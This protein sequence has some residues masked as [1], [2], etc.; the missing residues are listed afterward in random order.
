MKAF[1]SSSGHTFVFGMANGQANNRAISWDDPA[2]GSFVA[3]LDNE[4]GW[5]IAPMPIGADPN[6]TERDGSIFI[7]DTLEL[8]HCGKPF[9]W[10]IWTVEPAR[11]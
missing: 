10:G 8:R 6:V 2:T 5:I 9:V 3:K 4:A 1:V 11:Q 7:N